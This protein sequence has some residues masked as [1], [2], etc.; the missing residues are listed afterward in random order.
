[1]RSE[2]SVEKQQSEAKKKMH[3]TYQL[4]PTFFAPF[5]SAKRKY[6]AALNWKCSQVSLW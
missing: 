6:C 2:G 1:M 5:D 3:A 4:C